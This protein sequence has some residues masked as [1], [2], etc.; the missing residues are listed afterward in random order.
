MPKLSNENQLNLALQVMQ[1][2]TFLSIKHTASIYTVNHIILFQ[3]KRGTPSQRNCKLNM[4]NL[5]DLEKDTVVHRILELDTQRF[6]LRLRDVGDI[7]NKLLHNRDALP[8]KKNWTSNFIS[9]CPKLKNIFS[10]KY[11]YQ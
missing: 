11:D 2:D 3:C 8:V 5:T 10:R 1:Q 6:F 4:R 9:C 7:A